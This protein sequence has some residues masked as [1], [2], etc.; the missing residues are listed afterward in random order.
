MISVMMMDGFGDYYC[1]VL[2]IQ[3]GSGVMYVMG[4]IGQIFSLSMDMMM[5][6][7]EM[8]LTFYN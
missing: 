7:G 1:L 2:M 8:L 5:M 6:S 3:M 4:L